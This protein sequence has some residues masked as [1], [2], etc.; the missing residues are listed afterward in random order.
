MAVPGR[1]RGTTVGDQA[2]GLLAR[3]EHSR[4]ELAAKLSA[5]GWSEADVAHALD[6]LESAGL[7]SD[8]R[9]AESFV[10]ERAARGQGPAR[11]RHELRRRGVAPSLGEELVAGRAEAWREGALAARRKRFGS[12]RPQSYEERARQARFLERRGFE[13]EQIRYALETGEV[14]W[15]P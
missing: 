13:A 15:G 9:F 10:A 8:R 2:A 4:A 3:R 11:I 14:T 12:A 6:G 1:P 5:R 7:L